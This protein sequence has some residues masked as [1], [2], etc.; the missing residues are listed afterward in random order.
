MR[1]K[2]E[3]ITFD[4]DVNNETRNKLGEWFTMENEFSVFIDDGEDIIEVAKIRRTEN[5]PQYVWDDIISK[6]T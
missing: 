4:L 2:K 1:F 6:F 5:C 3:E